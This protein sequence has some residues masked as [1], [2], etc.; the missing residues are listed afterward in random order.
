MRTRTLTLLALLVPA[1]AGAVEVGDRVLAMRE[2]T[3]AFYPAT[4]TELGDEYGTPVGS[5]RFDDG[6]VQ[7][8]GPITFEP[9]LRP[10]DWRVGSTV[11]CGDTTG[12][13]TAIDATHVTI[14]G[15]THAVADCRYERTWWDEVHP[16]W[17]DYRTYK[18]IKKLPKKG[19]KSPGADE[20][21]SAFSYALETADG[22]AYL[23]IK[24]C[25][26]TGKTWSKITSGDELVAREIGVAC[27][28]AIPLP[29]KPQ[30]SFACVVE[31]GVCRQAYLGDG[32]YGGCEWKYTTA[33]PQQIACK[34]LK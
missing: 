34:K 20:V 15:A 5:V 10:F 14:D 8:Y 7:S 9:S 18:T 30:E 26:T 22:G 33:D 21:A 1:T 27:G 6:T 2:G 17:R 13:I 16:R 28:I 31:T 19:A 12:A 29:P 32:E 23:V 11:T 24:K 4:V 3:N 25:V